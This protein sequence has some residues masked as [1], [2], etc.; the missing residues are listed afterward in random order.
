MTNK[1]YIYQHTKHLDV[2]C[3]Y[4]SG[5]IWDYTAGKLINKKTVDSSKIDFLLCGY[6]LLN[7]P[8]VQMIINIQK[9]IKSYE[10]KRME[11]I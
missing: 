4:K 11:S 5:T 3:V 1:I 2:Y 9:Q 6:K 7:Y 10:N 8:P